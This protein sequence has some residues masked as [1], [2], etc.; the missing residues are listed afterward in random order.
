MSRTS[1]EIEQVRDGASDDAGQ[2]GLDADSS[3]GLEV[4]AADIEPWTSAL[5]ESIF[6]GIDPEVF[7][8]YCGDVD[9]GD[10]DA[11]REA[12]SQTKRAIDGGK[13]PEFGVAVGLYLLKRQGFEAGRSP[14]EHWRIH[15]ILNAGSRTVDVLV[16]DPRFRRRS[17]EMLMYR[18]L[19][20][21]LGR[22]QVGPR[23]VVAEVPCKID[24]NED[25]QDPWRSELPDVD[26]DGV[27]GSV[28]DWLL[29]EVLA[30]GLTSVTLGSVIEESDR[31]RGYQIDDV[32]GDW[33]AELPAD[34]A[35]FV[36]G[37]LFHPARLGGW[38]KALRQQL[39][40]VFGVARSIDDDFAPDESNIE[41]YQRLYEK[42]DKLRRVPKQLSPTYRLR[43][44]DQSWRGRWG[45][46]IHP[47]RRDR[48]GAQGYFAVEAGF[49]FDE[50]ISEAAGWSQRRQNDVR[51]RLRRIVETEDEE[52][53]EAFSQRLDRVV[54]VINHS[55][56]RLIGEPGGDAA[57]RPSPLWSE[58]TD[59]VEELSRIAAAD[60]LARLTATF[61]KWT[62]PCTAQT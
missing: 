55:P 49:Y 54:E 40:D 37:V 56:G 4:E 28:V 45:L 51:N 59:G 24:W 46:S 35:R 31:G 44:G 47:V 23:G 9:V 1:V 26:G 61:K 18:L 2:P 3:G 7:R 20:P 42:I 5:V 38:S 8:E 41:H 32:F 12:A 43:D 14:G 53:F 10:G 17:L 27:S 21:A 33:M 39:L 29:D 62:V 22:A 36:A 30:R 58:L 34:K 60:D 16:D 50:Q 25:H 52:C 48:Q 11:H 6:D 13:R 57:G 15:R 19:K